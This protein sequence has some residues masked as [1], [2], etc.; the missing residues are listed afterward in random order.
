MTEIQRVF[1]PVDFSPASDHA[2]AYAIALAK[3]CG[4]S[5]TLLH[6][7]GVPMY[8]LPEGFVTAYPQAVAAQSGLLQANLD[9]RLKQH[10]AAGVPLRSELTVGVPHTEIAEAAKRGKADLVIMGTHGYTGLKHMVLGSVAER[11]V[12]TSSVPVLTVRDTHP[13]PEVA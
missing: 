6:V 5:V 11:V 12:R 3:K 10:E 2:L 9:Q 13:I 7:Y 1:C 8:V 4:A